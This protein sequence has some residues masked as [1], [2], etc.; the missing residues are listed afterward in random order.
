MRQTA[1]ESEQ[2][3]LKIYTNTVK[4]R[5]TAVLFL[6]AYYARCLSYD[7]KPA[8][9]SEQYFRDAY[10]ARPLEYKTVTQMMR[11]LIRRKR[12]VIA[13]KWKATRVLDRVT[14]SFD[15]KVANIKNF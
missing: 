5:R 14:L 13:A 1:A 6:F 7:A 9:I 10:N 3:I 15:E 2:F 12:I 11:V 4:T 8:V